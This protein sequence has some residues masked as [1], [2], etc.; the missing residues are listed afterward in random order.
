VSADNAAESVACKEGKAD[1]RGVV[2]AYSC[3][4]REAIELG[5]AETPLC[6]IDIRG[7]PHTTLY[8]E[9]TGQNAA[10]I[11]LNWSVVDLSYSETVAVGAGATVIQDFQRVA[12]RVDAV[13]QADQETTEVN[14]A[15]CATI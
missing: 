13:G 6:E 14:V 15:L 8:V 10:T 4:Q 9:N 11:T 1:L 2:G 5:D 12:H 3:C 7:K